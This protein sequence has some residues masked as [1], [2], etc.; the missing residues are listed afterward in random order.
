MEDFLTV[1]YIS[2]HLKKEY[3]EFTYEEPKNAMTNIEHAA[4][5]DNEK[6][7]KIKKELINKVDK[8]SIKENYGQF[9]NQLK[10]KLDKL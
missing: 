9:I 3:P 2:E 8:K 4:K 1:E 6:K 5:T 10:E 7:Q